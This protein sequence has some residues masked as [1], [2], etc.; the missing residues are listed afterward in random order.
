M[1]KFKGE[2]I[3]NFTDQF[4]NDLDC[5]E[6]LAQIKWGNGFVCSNCAHKAHYS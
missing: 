4:K 2:N 3:L 6:Y 5:L 1:G